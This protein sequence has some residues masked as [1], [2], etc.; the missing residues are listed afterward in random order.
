MWA[1]TVHPNTNKV[2]MGE[3][4]RKVVNLE[5]SSLITRVGWG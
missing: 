5:I 3:K 2:W 4:V 1:K